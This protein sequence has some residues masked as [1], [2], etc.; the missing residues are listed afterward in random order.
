MGGIKIDVMS[1]I[2][3]TD[4]NYKGSIVNEHFI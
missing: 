1:I 2:H 3:I 4:N